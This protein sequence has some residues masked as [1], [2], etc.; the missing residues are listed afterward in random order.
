MFWAIMT[1]VPLLIGGGIVLST[2][3]ARRAVAW[4]ID[5]PWL[6]A[7]LVWIAPISVLTVAFTVTYIGLPFRRIRF[8]HALIG[9][10]IA[11]MLLQTLRWTFTLFIDASSSYWK[12]YG[13]LASIPIALLWVFLFWC[14]VLLGAEIVA[15]LPEWRRQ[16][17]GGAVYASLPVRRL[18]AALLMIEQ[19][20]RGRASGESTPSQRLT[21]AAAAALSDRDIRVA[22][23]ILVQLEKARV[24]V[25]IG[26]DWQLARDPAEVTIAELGDALDLGYGV[27]ADPAFLE[28]PWG[29]RLAALFLQT[30][31]LELSS[32]STSI[33]ALFH[34][35]AG[36]SEVSGVAARSPGR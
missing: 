26:H 16:R 14:I 4:G 33:E 25:A 19:L 32:L 13:I 24:I 10:A 17:A 3:A 18:T 15:C 12:L 20:L 27:N 29:K 11:A 30:H 36:L 35:Q 9:G 7:A 22:Q 6:T 1:I 23:D 31:A 2:L 8:V 34:P 28:A 5:V 21:E